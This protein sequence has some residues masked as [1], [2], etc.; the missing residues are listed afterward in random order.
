MIQIFSG[1]V[2]QSATARYSEIVLSNDYSAHERN[3]IGSSFAVASSLLYTI[4]MQAIG[5]VGSS[6]FQAALTFSMS[7]VRIHTFV[8]AAGIHPFSQACNVVLNAE[9]FDSLLAYLST[10]LAYLI[11][12]AAFY[13]VAKVICPCLDKASQAEA[14]Q[15]LY[16]G[17]SIRR[18]VSNVASPHFSNRPSQAKVVE[19]ADE[20]DLEGG[21][22]D[23]GPPRSCNEPDTDSDSSDDE[24]GPVFFGDAAPCNRDGCSRQAKYNTRGKKRPLC[25][26]QHATTAMVNVVD[27][28]CTYR[29]CNEVA[30]YNVKNLRTGKFCINHKLVGMVNVTDRETSWRIRCQDAF[31]FYLRLPSTVLAPDLL[32][33]IVSGRLPATLPTNAK[34]V[35]KTKLKEKQELYDD[36]RESQANMRR[37]GGADGTMDR[38][39]TLQTKSSL[40]GRQDRLRRLVSSMLQ[41]IKDE[42]V[43][44]L[45]KFPAGRA[46]EIKWEE[47]KLNLALPSY[48]TLLRHEYRELCDMSFGPTTLQGFAALT[49]VEFLAMLFLGVTQIGHVATSHG[50]IACVQIFKRYWTFLQVCCGYWSRSTY[51]AYEGSCREVG[52]AFIFSPC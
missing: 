4:C 24:G 18:P 51:E 35:F 40:P 8:E 45:A 22:Q 52:G 33:A 19:R 17:T 3:G 31:F 44:P 38:R 34:A 16:Y 47:T 48:W 28:I 6:V 32:L 42:A 37:G 1:L 20:D 50:R 41:H 11:L 7:F 12:P 49:V 25:C 26:K 2:F 9:G 10:A 30:K 36:F 13:E 27:D 39:G 23:A 5:Q 21:G 15:L 14:K 43:I 29:E 46:E